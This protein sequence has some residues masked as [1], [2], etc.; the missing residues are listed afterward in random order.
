MSDLENNETPQT[1]DKPGLKIFEGKTEK[2]VYGSY[3]FLAATLVTWGLVFLRLGSTSVVLH[4]AIAPSIGA[5]TVAMILGIGRNALSAASTST[6]AN[7]RIRDL[8]LC[9]FRE[10]RAALCSPTL[11]RVVEI[12]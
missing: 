9:R 12:A 7:R 3:L 11:D 4:A 8:A 6:P 10:Q 1:T 5:L 2:W